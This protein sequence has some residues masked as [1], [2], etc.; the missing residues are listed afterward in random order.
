MTSPGFDKFSF[1]NGSFTKSSMNDSTTMLGGTK[2]NSTFFNTGVSMLKGYSMLDDSS[3]DDLDALDSSRHDSLHLN[4]SLTIYPGDFTGVMEKSKIRMV[5]T[6]SEPWKSVTEELFMNF[7]ETLRINQGEVQFFSQVS[8]F[9]VNC[10]DCAKIIEQ[11]RD[12]TESL[13]ASGLNE[14]LKW[15]RNERDIWRLVDCLYKDR[16]MD[17]ANGKQDDE[18]EIDPTRHLSEKEAVM[19]LYRDD[20]ILRQC[21]LVIDWLEKGAADESESDRLMHLE[22]FTDH[23]IGWENTLH[24]LQNQEKGIPYTST[25]PIVTQMDPD[26]PLREQKPL[27]DLDQ[28]DEVRLARQIF[29]LIRCGQ[30]E[31][32]QMLCRHCG[33]EWRAST[34]NGWRLFHDPNYSLSH[35]PHTQKVQI[36]GNP[37]R[38]LWK[39]I[40][41]RL[42]EDEKVHPCVRASYGALCGHVNSI[43]N[44]CS[45][46]KDHLWARLRCSVDV[47]VESHVR[48]ASVAPDGERVPLPEEYWRGRMSLEQ[49]FSELASSRDAKVRN[50]ASMLYNIV[51]KCVVLEHIDEM[52]TEAENW[53]NH[54]NPLDSMP[55]PHVLR[56]LA[57]FVLFLRQI[58]CSSHGS[59]E[60][61]ILRA[62]VQELMKKREPQ[63]VAFYVSVLPHDEQVELY[64]SFLESIVDVEEKNNCL[65]FA[66]KFHLNVDEITKRVVENI[67]SREIKCVAQDLQEE[68]TET[69]L[70]KIR[71]LDFLV[72]FPSQR[73][74]AVWQGNA[75]IRMFLAA[76]KLEGAN[77]ALEKIPMDSIKII[78]DQYQV[79]NLDDKKLEGI[80]LSGKV[81]RRIENSIREYFCYK[82]YLEA[83]KSFSDWFQH[84][85]HAKP[86]EPVAP[87][88]I[89]SFTKK[90]AMEQ[91]RELYNAEVERWNLGVKLQS[92]TVKSRL[93]NILLFPEG[94]LVDVESGDDMAQLMRAQGLS[95]EDE[96]RRRRWQQ[97]KDLRELYIPQVVM[98][99]HT[100]MES[101]GE[102]TECL[103]LAEVVVSEQHQLYKVY[104]KEKL[105]ELL[106][107]ISGTC[108]TLLKKTKDPW[109]IPTV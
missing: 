45:T 102:L 28:E 70:E 34:F 49:L 58:G 91:Q 53:I 79:R 67:R 36:E 48:A 57:H 93:Y 89:N 52:M 74:E 12:R 40:A 42:A 98:L 41:W 86:K 6:S 81:P 23:T 63:L 75:I 17:S 80:P 30:M 64:A 82:A 50:E 94:W 103:Q 5:Q 1:G 47:I 77:Q 10:T 108:L 88:G 60:N 22:A 97:M 31:R 29:L 100:V 92:K 71:A 101:A 106:Y 44:V 65:E 33:Q 104:T 109:G 9:I 95:A 14:E 87:Q 54:S 83:Q 26:A 4:K 59:A 13:G 69:D 11:M 16:L 84:Y 66:E 105:D 90:V 21:Q 25:Q 85:H 37:N 61:A 8:D 68:L 55:R 43:L 39:L 2:R 20:A 107:K 24:Q 56:F 96:E 78:L 76:G 19:N 46:W 73:A 3:L 15:L 32:A 99:L 27:H 51:L 35:M 7:F 62:Y 18:E 38:D 72:F